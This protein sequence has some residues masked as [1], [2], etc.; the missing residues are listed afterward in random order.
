MLFVPET[1]EQ[2]SLVAQWVKCLPPAH[3]MLLGSWDGAPHL[4]AHLAPHPGPAPGLHWA[5]HLAPHQPASGPA[6]GPILVPT[7]SP[8]P[9][10]APSPSSGSLLS[11]G[12]ASPSLCRLL[13]RL[14][15]LSLI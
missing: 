14:P 9:S 12:P 15:P 13:P 2:G 8:A 6:P 3:I 5:P 11:G 7:L 10:P 4:V 1:A